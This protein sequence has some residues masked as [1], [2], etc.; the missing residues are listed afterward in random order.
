MEQLNDL[1]K[2]NNAMEFR[3]SQLVEINEQLESKQPVY[4]A[5]RQS[6]IDTEVA[7]FINNKYPE[8]TERLKIMFIRESEGVYT[9]GS[10][11]V[12]IK[13]EK[14]N[15]L[16]VRVGGGYMHIEEFV[17]TFTEIELEK[18][19]R[20]DALHRFREKLAV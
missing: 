20:R 1:Q 19:E 3:I 6:K 10:K 2:T 14:G 5:R 18:V 16:F 4:I 8:T 13:C 12:Y 7:R 15:Q 9:F 11:R 17:K